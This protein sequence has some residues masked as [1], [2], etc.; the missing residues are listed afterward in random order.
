[1]YRYP[2]NELEMN[3]YKK[4]LEEIKALGV[5]VRLGRR[6]SKAVEIATK[7]LKE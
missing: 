4:A 3:R 6:I 7:A 5:D 1:M 2:D